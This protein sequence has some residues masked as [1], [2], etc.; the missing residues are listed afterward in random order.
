MSLV[1][2]EVKEEPPATVLEPDLALAP[3]QSA[4]PSEGYLQVLENFK[5]EMAEM[6]QVEAAVAAEQGAM[7]VSPS[8][9]QKHPRIEPV[10]LP[11]ERVDA[12][13]TDQASHDQSHDQQSENKGQAPQVSMEISEESSLPPQQRAVED[14]TAAH[15]HPLPVEPAP[16][17]PQ[18]PHA[19]EPLKAPAVPM[20]VG[21]SATHAPLEPEAPINEDGASE[22]ME[23]CESEAGTL[24]MSV[25]EPESESEG[26]V[27]ATAKP[28]AKSKSRAK[29]KA[30]PKP[31][32]A[33][34]FKRPAAAKSKASAKS[35]PK[36]KPKA[37][38]AKAKP[39]QAKRPRGKNAKALE[40]IPSITSF[41]STHEDLD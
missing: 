18:R 15:S 4:G 9:S 6:D 34:A 5:Q 38:I 16:M 25:V 2:P 8:S 23:A 12:D 17:S 3:V 14:L 20:D 33:A 37:T 7:A 27:V 36:A 21:S 32:T 41:M 24:D 11:S 30:T 1:L 13:M 22:H 35:K 31:K 26:Q 10:P 40:G 29:P 28:K 39:Q 19:V